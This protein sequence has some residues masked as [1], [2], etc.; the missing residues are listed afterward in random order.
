MSTWIYLNLCWISQRCGFMQFAELKV[1]VSSFAC[2]H[3]YFMLFTLQSIDFFKMDWNFRANQWHNQ[4]QFYKM[5]LLCEIEEFGNSFMMLLLK[6]DLSSLRFCSMAVLWSWF[7]LAWR[8]MLWF[9]LDILMV[10]WIHQYTSDL[11]TQTGS[12]LD[13][14]Q[15][16][17][18]Q[19]NSCS[20]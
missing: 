8:S 1:K 4:T 6:M 14:N 10:K 2:C 15:P 19:T 18:P 20:D 5:Q 12:C 16:R 11:N 13:L 7:K 9:L 3:V 17:F